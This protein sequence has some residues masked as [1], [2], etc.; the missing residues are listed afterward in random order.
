MANEQNTEALTRK[1]MNFEVGDD[2][3][4][5][6]YAQSIDHSLTDI[7]D[8]LSKAGGKPKEFSLERL[9]DA[10]YKPKGKAKPEY[11]IT[12]K[13]D[14]NTILVI[15]CK[16]S[17]KMHSS[18]ENT[19]DFPYPRG[20][21]VDGV[22]YYSYFLKEKFNVIAVA[23]SGNE[24]AYKVNEYYWVKGQ[25]KPLEQERTRNTFL[26]PK[27]YKDL[28][29]NKKLVKK[30][31][32]IEIKEKAIEFNEHL[33][34]TLKIEPSKRIMFI[35]G[36][37]LA[38]K[39]SS[40]QQSYSKGL[41]TK[42]IIQQMIQSIKN[43]LSEHNIPQTKINLIT[44]SCS[45]IEDYKEINEIDPQLQGSLL[46]FLKQLDLCIIPMINDD[47]NHQD[48]LGLF[49]HE[50]I[51]YTAGGTG[52]EL[53]IVLTPP[54]LCDFM[55]ELAEINKND[56]VID[57]CCGTGSFLI[58]AMKH[59]FA[60][61]NENEI[62]EIKQKH[63]Y[64]VEV[65]PDIFAIA[66]TNMIIRGDGQSHIYNENSFN[67]SKDLLKDVQFNIGLIN[68]PY[69]QKDHCELEFVETMLNLLSVKGRGVVVVPMSCAIGTKFKEVRKRLFE[70]H[71][72]KAVFS[73][74]DDIFYPVGTNV[75]VM[76][77]EAH[78]PHDG[79]KKTYFGYYKDDGFKK[80]K[81]LGRVDYQ[82]KWE[83]IKK[84]WVDNYI[85]KKVIVGQS[86]LKAVKH[87]D[88]WLCEAY[89]ETDYSLLSQKDFQQTVNDY[90]A[91]LVKNGS[92]PTLLAE[93]HDTSCVL[94]DS[95]WKEFKLSDLFKISGSVTTPI[96]KLE[97]YGEG[98][99]PYV[100]TQAV[101]NGVESFYNYYTEEGDC[102]TVD[103]AVLGYCS[104]QCEKFSASD[105]VEVL[106]PKYKFNKYIAMFLVTIMNKEQYRYSY[107][108]KCSQTKLKSTIL[109]LPVIT[110]EDGTYEPDWK[111]MENYIKSLPYGDRI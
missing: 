27:N 52:N 70:K 59:M 111:Y 67:L 38:L 6:V 81:K 64:G 23:V 106:R 4:F 25:P 83:S 99:Y 89:M 16:S 96:D 103:S 33:R 105:H 9:N 41:P 108:R 68:P 2:V 109:K 98:K 63:L 24:K 72:L 65:T 26:T 31:S 84:E 18:S 79:S 12:Y 62:S 80:K 34:N 100:T 92:Y 53:G 87:S 82:N 85:D 75:C 5:V 45:F 78:T 73:M 107:G 30:F 19:T 1:N 93:H 94:S 17:I 95:E 47:T 35:A 20:Y 77:W 76:V 86:T 11:I 28:I 42:M 44:K 71:T 91:F 60:N 48:S 66:V 101:N 10:A 29:D 51:K 97:E 36:C 56:Y 21:A 50:F 90:C 58:S 43:V 39:D 55:C 57:T 15:E 14:P 37:L 46:Y 61:A 32:Y 49:Y 40:F 54:H 3:D 104:Y 110:K 102:L 88:E 8:C 74:P 7:S 69:S 13:D 22:L